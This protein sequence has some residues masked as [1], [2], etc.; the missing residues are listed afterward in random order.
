MVSHWTP[1]APQ[2]PEGS[3]RRGPR[4]SELGAHL[5]AGSVSEAWS[6]RREVR[7]AW[8]CPPSPR[9]GG[10]WDTGGLRPPEATGSLAC[11][12]PWPG[13]EGLPR[14]PPSP[15]ARTP[16]GGSARC[17]VLD[18]RR[19]HAPSCRTRVPQGR[20]PGAWRVQGVLE[21]ELG[22]KA[23]VLRP[24]PGSPQVNTA[25]LSSWGRRLLQ[26]A[27][28]AGA[29]GWGR[30]AALSCPGHGHISSGRFLLACYRVRGLTA[31]SSG[32]PRGNGKDGT[33]VNVHCGD[34]LPATTAAAAT[35]VRE[36]AHR[37]HARQCDRSRSPT[38]A[39][40]ART[41]VQPGD[42][43]TG[44]RSVCRTRALHRSSCGA[45]RQRTQEEGTC[46]LGPAPGRQ[47]RPRESACPARAPWESLEG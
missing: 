33:V 38:Q 44:C 20:P 18:C 10:R 4:S 40:S 28:A 43:R 45:H 8:R 29:G 13:R 1:R 34:W 15:A 47:G 19:R 46:C 42:R 39:I 22:W 36:T 6:A 3:Q 11:G 24:L 12:P 30:V 32:L 2:E 31:P 17:W 41:R 26:V 23:G 5:G 35:D 16:A 9:P 27:G 14:I 37:R 25:G 7:G 21:G